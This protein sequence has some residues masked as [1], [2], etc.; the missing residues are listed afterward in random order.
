SQS[1]SIS[2]VSLLSVSLHR[3]R[4]HEHRYISAALSLFP[5]RATPIE[6]L[7]TLSQSVITQNIAAAGLKC[8]KE[9]NCWKRGHT[10][11]RLSP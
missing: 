4:T 7:I 10:I 8:L 2:S 11:F 1:D 5:L 9:E 3:I 6:L